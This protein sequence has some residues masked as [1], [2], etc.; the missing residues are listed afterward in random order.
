ML[1][2]TV[3][4][5]NNIFR[6]IYRSPFAR[7]RGLNGNIFGE[8]SESESDISFISSERPSVDRMS[9]LHEIVDS[10]RTSRVSTSSDSS[11]GSER[12]GSKAS[13][14]SSFHEFSSSS[15]ENVSSVVILKQT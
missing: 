11:Y 2:N 13:D 6:G 3:K 8:L 10:G 15:I 12:F 4:L 7:G 14:F 5:A 1:L 9:A